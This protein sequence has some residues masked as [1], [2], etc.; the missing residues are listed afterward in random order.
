MVSLLSYRGKQEGRNPNSINP[1]VESFPISQISRRIRE[2]WAAHHDKAENVA[3]PARGRS[4][5]TKNLS[6][7]VVKRSYLNGVRTPSKT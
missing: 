3:L 7:T 6:G 5:T 1:M 2:K 4:K